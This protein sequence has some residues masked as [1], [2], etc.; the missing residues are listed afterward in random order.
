[1]RDVQS[2]GRGAHVIA[3][4]AGYC[5]GNLH[6]PGENTARC[7]TTGECRGPG[8]ELWTLNYENPG[9]NPVLLC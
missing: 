2:T 5:F 8:V 9:S 6:I 3:G 1:M 7:R 4:T